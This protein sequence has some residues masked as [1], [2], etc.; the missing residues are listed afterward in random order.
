MPR[1]TNITIRR[2]SAQNWETANPVLNSGELGFDTTN[3]IVK[4]GN[5]VDT[6]TDLPALAIVNPLEVS[7]SYLHEKLVV[8]TPIISFKT[9]TNTTIFTVPADHMFFIDTME[10]ITTS[11]SSPGLAPVVQFG[12]TGD[13]SAYYS[14]NRTTSNSAGSRHVIQSPQNGIT[15]GTSVTFGIQTASTAYSHN[16]IAV[17]TGY[18]LK[19]ESAAQLYAIV[20]PKKTRM[21]VQW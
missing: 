21:F 11:I 4:I 2:G 19:V 9:E 15:S 13:Y 8:Q 1:E 17:V 6:W 7:S 20:S 12:N 16:G 3:N 14:L 10:V 18:V 5:Q